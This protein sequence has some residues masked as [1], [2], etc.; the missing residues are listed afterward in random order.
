MG[1]MRGQDFT[2]CNI[3]PYTFAADEDPPE[4]G[5]FIVSARGQ[6][7]YRI[8]R[9]HEL[10]QHDPAERRYKVRCTRW[11]RD[12]IPA[13]ALTYPIYWHSRNKR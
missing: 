6:A 4:V 8:E 11:P 5:A 13:D 10:P 7:A 12:Q 1:G 2:P 3:S 9:V